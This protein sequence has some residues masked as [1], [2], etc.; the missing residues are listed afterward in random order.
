MDRARPG[1]H[2]SKPQAIELGIA[3]VTLFNL[4]PKQGMAVP[5]RRQ[6]I[7]LAWA[8]VGA[9]AM[10]ELSA[11][12]RPHRLRHGHLLSGILPDWAAIAP[13]SAIL[14]GEVT[15]IRI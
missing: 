11:L 14:S 4:D 6:G 12:D 9:I 2:P 15:R 5:V 3:M 13:A 10:G 8:A 7:E 1:K